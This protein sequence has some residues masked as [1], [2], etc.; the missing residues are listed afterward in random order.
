[1]GN[2]PTIPGRIAMPKTWEEMSASEKL[3]SLRSEVDSLNRVTDSVA[4]RIEEIRNELK[5][6]ESVV[7]ARKE[8][9]S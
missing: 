6:V 5:A 9:L 8:N 4:R 7:S 1:L 2:D 3:N